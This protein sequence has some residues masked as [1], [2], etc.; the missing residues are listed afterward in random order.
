MTDVYTE[1]TEFNGMECGR[2]RQR[3]VVV[4]G[5][6]I[7]HGPLFPNKEIIGRVDLEGKRGAKYWGYV[8]RSGLITVMN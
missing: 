3:L 4:S 6:R 5:R 7:N 2:R 8:H 1:T